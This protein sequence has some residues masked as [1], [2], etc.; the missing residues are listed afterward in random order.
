[1]IKWFKDLF[2][3]EE[4]DTTLPGMPPIPTLPPSF[5]QAFTSSGFTQSFSVY[6]QEEEK[7]KQQTRDEIKKLSPITQSILNDLSK[8]DTFSKQYLS[9]Y[10]AEVNL[11]EAGKIIEEHIKRAS[12]DN[13]MQEIIN[14][15]D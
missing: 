2:K 6:L 13:K 7:L 11:L 9:V 3:D 4:E 8:T 12:F 5:S 14:E 1:M 10:P 15:K